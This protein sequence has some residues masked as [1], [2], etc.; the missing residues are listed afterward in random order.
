[1]S[2]DPLPHWFSLAFELLKMVSILYQ[3][4]V[5]LKDVIDQCSSLHVDVVGRKCDLED[6]PAAYE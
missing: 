5:I 1:L 2:V 6:I 3:D 4:V